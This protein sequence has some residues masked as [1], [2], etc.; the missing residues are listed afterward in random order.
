M[1]RKNRYVF[2]VKYA[3]HI[4]PQNHIPLSSLKSYFRFGFYNDFWSSL[5]HQFWMT[6][7][8]N[9]PFFSVCNLI[10]VKSLYVPCGCIMSEFYSVSCDFLKS[11]SWN[12]PRVILNQLRVWNF[13]C[14]CFNYEHFPN[15][16]CY[17]MGYVSLFCQIKYS[18]WR[19]DGENTSSF[20]SLTT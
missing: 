11:E 2:T 9:L 13:P 16:P 20:Y 3:P 4:T 6:N 1:F 14:Y 17:S 12:V 19:L 15:V 10:I 5:W 7:W 18:C 8:R